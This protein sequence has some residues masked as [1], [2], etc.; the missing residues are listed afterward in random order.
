MFDIGL[1]LILGAVAGACGGAVAGAIVAFIKGYR[2][3]LA[4]IT[5][6]SGRINLAK[7]NVPFGTRLGGLLGMLLGGL[8]GGAGSSELGLSTAGILGTLGYIRYRRVPVSGVVIFW[9]LLVGA[10]TG[11]AGALSTTVFFSVLVGSAA[12][13]FWSNRLFRQMNFQP[14]EQDLQ[15]VAQTRERVKQLLAEIELATKRSVESGVWV[16]E[17]KQ[18]LASGGKL[19]AIQMVRENTG[20]GLAEAAQLVSWERI[21]HAREPAN[22]TLQPPSRTLRRFQSA[23][24]CSRGLRLNVEP[25]DSRAGFRDRQPA[26]DLRCQPVRDFG[27]SRDRFDRAC[28]RIRPEGM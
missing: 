26:A 10:V 9:S 4:Q 15:R 25:L 13:F 20:L 11:Y 27:V 6:K 17:A 3:P 24:V 14:S 19:S 18:L 22:K 28:C 23:T 12:F 8:A 1:S 16:E 21:P 2:S 7:V 5:D